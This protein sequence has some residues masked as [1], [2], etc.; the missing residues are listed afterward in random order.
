MVLSL[1]TLPTL[2]QPVV[3]A[4]RWISKS[5]EGLRPDLGQELTLFFLMLLQVILRQRVQPRRQ[6]RPKP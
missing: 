1:D 3:I 5:P 2:F 6:Y 4:L